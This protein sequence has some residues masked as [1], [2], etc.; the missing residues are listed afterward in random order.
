MSADLI[1]SYLNANFAKG[2]ALLAKP[3]EFNDTLP[4]RLRPK[5]NHL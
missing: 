4:I 3:L 2:D 1:K 5:L